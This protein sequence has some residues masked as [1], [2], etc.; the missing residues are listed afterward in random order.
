VPVCH[1]ITKRCSFEFEQYSGPNVVCQC[2]PRKQSN[3]VL[4]LSS[5][6][7]L[8]RV[9]VCHLKTKSYSFE[10][11]HYNGLGSCASVPPEN[12]EIQFEFNQYSGLESCA[13]VPLKKEEMQF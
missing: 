10:F 11:E 6:V 8:S 4:N 2:A 7:D 5:T 3:T 9:P 1:P 12:K 13:S